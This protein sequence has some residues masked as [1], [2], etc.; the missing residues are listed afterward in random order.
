MFYLYI[1]KVTTYVTNNRPLCTKHS[2][3]AMHMYTLL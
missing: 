1:D 2:G 3:A